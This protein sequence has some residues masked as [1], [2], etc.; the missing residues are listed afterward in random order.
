MGFQISFMLAVEDRSFIPTKDQIAGVFQILK[1]HDVIS[2]STLLDIEKALEGYPRAVDNE[3]DHT[4]LMMDYS[5][6]KQFLKKWLGKDYHCL[7]DALEADPDEIPVGMAVSNTPFKESFGDIE[8]VEL[9]SCFSVM[10]LWLGRAY[11]WDDDP[12]DEDISEEDFEEAGD[13]QDRLG[14]SFSKVNAILI[15]D[16]EAY[17][18]RPITTM[19][20]MS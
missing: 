20:D 11:C 7:T 4:L 15:A 8:E 1:N 19:M 9:P 3:E 12:N 18:K 10:T 13:K 5:V 17:L 2:A 16:L 14:D 6:K